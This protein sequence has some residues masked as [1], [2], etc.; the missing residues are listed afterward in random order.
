MIPPGVL[1][2]SSMT[3]QAASGCSKRLSSS[4]QLEKGWGARPSFSTHP[5]TPSK[6]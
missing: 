1:V 6:E 2:R 4:N 5:L 3:R